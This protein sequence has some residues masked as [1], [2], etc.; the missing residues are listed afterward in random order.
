[1][2]V[3]PH[4]CAGRRKRP[5]I[6]W[7]SLTG[8]ENLFF[9]LRSC[10]ILAEN[11]LAVKVPAAPQP[12]GEHEWRWRWPCRYRRASL[13]EGARPKP[14]SHP[15]TSDCS[16]WSCVSGFSQLTEI[17]RQELL[18]LLCVSYWQWA[19]CTQPI[20]VF[21]WTHSFYFGEGDAQNKYNDQP[22]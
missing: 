8:C 6:P 21:V 22:S 12:V 1:M 11:V 19:C 2:C 5:H 20:A 14:G 4:V 18:Q 10:S 3:H 17:N 7:A 13:R 15:N 16:A 9:F